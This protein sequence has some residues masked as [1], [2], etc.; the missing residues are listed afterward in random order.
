MTPARVD[1]HEEVRRLQGCLNDLISV[2]ALPALWSGRGPMEIV[3]ALLDGTVRIL[4]LEFAYARLPHGFDGAPRELLRT[5]RAGAAPA[6][7]EVIGER[8]M[9]LLRKP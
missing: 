1:D 8:L 6:P 9:G 3:E 7:L 2:M 5:L 4:R